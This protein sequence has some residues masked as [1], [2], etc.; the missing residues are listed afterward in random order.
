MEIKPH[1]NLQVK[2]WFVLATISFLIILVGII[3]QVLISTQESVT[4]SQVA[5]ILWPIIFGTIILLSVIYI[6]IVILWIKN[7]TYFIENDRITINKGIL[8][9]IQ[10]NIPY[11]AITD[12]KLHLSLYDRFLNIGSVRIQTAGQSTSATGYEGNLSGLEDWENLHQQL[13]VKLKDLYSTVDSTTNENNSDH[14]LNV[15][16]LEDILEELKTIRKVLEDK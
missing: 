1:K 9:K 10:Q 7:L 5:I 2:Q 16:K 6:P 12:F 14:S 8:S 11:R 15:D 13:R 4:A 3:L